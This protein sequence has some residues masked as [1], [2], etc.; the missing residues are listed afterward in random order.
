MLLNGAG[1]NRLVNNEITAQWQGV[2]LGS[3]ANANDVIANRISG[4][5]GSGISLE[6]ETSGNRVHGNRV[7]C[8]EDATWCEIIQAAPEVW[9]ANDISG[10]TAW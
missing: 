3:G 10:N 8:A 1:G 9:E 4:V 2:L 7:A 5:Q 6:W